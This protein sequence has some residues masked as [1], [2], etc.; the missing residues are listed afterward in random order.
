MASL[1]PLPFVNSSRILSYIST[2]ASTDIPI[3]NIIP[4]IPGNVNT[5][6]REDNTPKIKKILASKAT[7]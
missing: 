3:V 7:F 5:A 2:L 1:I 4:A 6:P